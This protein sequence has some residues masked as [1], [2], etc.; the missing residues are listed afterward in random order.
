MMTGTVPG[1]R[2]GFYLG[3]EGPAIELWQQ[4]IQDDGSRGKPPDLLQTLRAIP[5][6]LDGIARLRQIDTQEVCPF[7]IVFDDQHQGTCRGWLD[8]SLPVLDRV[9][10]A[11]RQGY[12]ALRT[13]SPAA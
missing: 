8:R 6:N 12:R 2:I 10:L 11:S 3:K 7:R 1:H 5:G 4:D 13:A 9:L